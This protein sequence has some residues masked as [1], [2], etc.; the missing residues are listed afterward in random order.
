MATFTHAIINHKVQDY[1][2]RSA[3][4]ARLGPL[5]AWT[6]QPAH[7]VA[8]FV[9]YSAP[10]GLF[11]RFG[12]QVAV[13]TGG[14]WRD[15][16]A[17]QPARVA[18]LASFRAVARTIGGTRLL[19]LPDS[20]EVAYDAVIEGLSQDQCIAALRKECGPPHSLEDPSLAEAAACGAPQVWFLESVWGAP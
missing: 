9:D 13:L 5:G 10:E 20:I 7:L 18:A 15:F 1:R 8:D 12:R 14:R 4:L 16:L 17:D 3:V 6:A 19:L 2:D 11:L